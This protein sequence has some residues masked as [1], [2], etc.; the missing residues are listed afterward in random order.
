MQIPVSEPAADFHAESLRI[1]L[2]LS[3]QIPPDRPGMMIVAIRDPASYTGEKILWRD[4]SSGALV[5]QEW[6][7]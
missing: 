1:P 6:P 4:P 3:G 5:V 7:N 2:I